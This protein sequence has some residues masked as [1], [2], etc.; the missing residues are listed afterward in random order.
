[1]TK[2]IIVGTARSTAPGVTK[3]NLKIG[4]TPAGRSID[5]PVV[6]VQGEKEGPVVWMHACVHGNEYCGTFIIHEFLNSLDPKTLK[7]TV[8]AIPVLNVTAFEKKL[9][10]SP[11]EGF[12]GGDMNRQ[13]PGNPGGTLTQ[14]MAYALYEPL[15]TYA[16][17]LIDFHTALTPDVRWALFPK[18]GKAA[19]TSEKVAKAF[20]YRDTLPVPDELL[21]GSAMMTAAKDGI[22]SYI[23]ECGGKLRSFTDESVTDAVERLTNVLRAL[24]MLEGDVVD[25]GKMNYFSSFEWVTAKQGGLFER[26]VKCGDTVEEGTEIGR[27]FDMHGNERGK[28]LAPKAGIVLA[29]HS[30]PIMASGETLIH[31]GLDPKEVRA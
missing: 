27:Y 11:F 25:Y 10:M 18:N 3:G 1:M 20:G 22:A 6:I 30:G 17:V 28:A 24:E 23:V 21:A 12:N 26:F 9:R 13:F 16:D 4:E 7:G 2:E 19:A 31:I 29:I 15:K 5:A 8:V 14:Q